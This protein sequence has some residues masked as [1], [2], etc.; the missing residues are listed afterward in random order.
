MTVGLK[1]ERGEVEHTVAH[2]IKT[3]VG[4][5][6][7]AKYFVDIVGHRRTDPTDGF[8]NVHKILKENRFGLRVGYEEPPCPPVSKKPSYANSA[9][10]RVPDQEHLHIPP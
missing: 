7:F 8:L 2:K 4:P 9:R 5:D 10:D 1:A 3:A 6:D